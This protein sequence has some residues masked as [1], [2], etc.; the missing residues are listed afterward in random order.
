MYLWESCESIKRMF[1]NNLEIQTK[2]ACRTQIP[3]LFQV[4]Y[5]QW[6]THMHSMNMCVVDAAAVILKEVLPNIL[7]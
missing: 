4:I 3:V 1:T 2:Q 7:N 6:D 5:L